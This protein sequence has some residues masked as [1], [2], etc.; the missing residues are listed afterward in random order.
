MARIV[1]GRVQGTNSGS[2][3]SEVTSA[4]RKAGRQGLGIVGLTSIDPWLSFV[5]RA[6]ARE[7]HSLGY[8]LRRLCITLSWI[9]LRY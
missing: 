5:K 7:A 3:E 9:N 4:S 1:G 6:H 8:F 2:I